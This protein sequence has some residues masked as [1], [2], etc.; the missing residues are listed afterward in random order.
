MRP[1]LGMYLFILSIIYKT[2]SYR[3]FI[4]G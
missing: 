4:D 2:N 1:L 3:L